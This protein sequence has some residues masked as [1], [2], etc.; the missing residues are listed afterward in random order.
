MENIATR[1]Y[2]KLRVEF[3]KFKEKNPF[4]HTQRDTTYNFIS[5]YKDA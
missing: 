2:L 5:I 4:L 1:P 3:Y